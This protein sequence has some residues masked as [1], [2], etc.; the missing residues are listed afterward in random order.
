MPLSREEI[1]AA[2]QESL[3]RLLLNAHRTFM[4]IFLE[5]MRQQGVDQRIN[6][7]LTNIMINIP[8][9]GIRIADIAEAT[10]MTRQSVSQFVNELETIGYVERI[11]DPADGRA[12]LIRFSTEGL[13]VMRY[14]LQVKHE[15]E[16]EV[17]KQ[18]TANGYAALIDALKTIAS[19]DHH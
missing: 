2:R 10:N 17:A 15:I 5:K 9:S 4:S 11:P 18:L 8:S 6:A 19:M 14:A 7:S 1:E 3:G 12:V 13:V 16:S